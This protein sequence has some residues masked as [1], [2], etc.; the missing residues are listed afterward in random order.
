[1][2]LRGTEDE[3]DTGVPADTQRAVGIMREACKQGSSD[4]CHHLSSLLLKGGLGVA[5]DAPGARSLMEIGCDQGYAP[6]CY[7]LAVMFKKGDEG[8]PP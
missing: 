6:C 1:M 7:N 3:C 5:K 4:S 8:V 2:L